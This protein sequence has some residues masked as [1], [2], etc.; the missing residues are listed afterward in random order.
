MENMR[1][2]VF[3]KRKPTPRPSGPPSFRTLYH[4]MLVLYV[5]PHVFIIVRASSKSAFGHH[6]Y[7]WLLGSASLPTGSSPISSKDIVVYRCSRLCS[8][9]IFPVRLAKRQGGSIRIVPNCL[10][11]PL[12][13]NLKRSFR[14]FLEAAFSVSS[15]SLNGSRIWSPLFGTIINSAAV[16]SKGLLQAI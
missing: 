6:R 9:A 12:N 15:A 13:S 8:G 4:T 11:G 1:L 7:K 3:R 10:Y 5:K 14:S 16:E 2:A